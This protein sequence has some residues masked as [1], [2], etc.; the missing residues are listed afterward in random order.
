MEE[1]RKY[2]FLSYLLDLIELLE[3][4]FYRDSNLRVKLT[5]GSVK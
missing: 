5:Y 1:N 4:K 2:F 3:Q